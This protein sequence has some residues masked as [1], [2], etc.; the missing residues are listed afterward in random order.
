MGLVATTDGVGGTTALGEVGDVVILKSFT[1]L[2]FLFLSKS[3]GKQ[4]EVMFAI[5]AISSFS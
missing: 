3:N 5:N 2:F 4:M 1:Q